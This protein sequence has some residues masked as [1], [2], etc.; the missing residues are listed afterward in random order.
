MGTRGFTLTTKKHTLICI[1]DYPEMLQF[2]RGMLEHSGYAVLT[3]TNGPQGLKMLAGNG[4]SGVVVDFD[5]PGM[6][7]GE[8]AAAIRAMRPRIP[9]LMLSGSIVAEEVLNLVDG[10]LVK[11]RPINDLAQ[12]VDRFFKQFLGLVTAA[13]RSFAGDLA[14]PAQ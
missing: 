11:S 9:I 8:V 1:D 7:G 3:A 10:F 12:E 14:P 2:L 6:N 5:M 13:D 4:V